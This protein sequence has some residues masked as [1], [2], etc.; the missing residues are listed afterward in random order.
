MNLMANKTFIP[1]FKAKV[2]DWNYYICHMKYAEVAKQVSFAYE[3]GGNTEL[4][5]MIQRGI[6]SR[7]EDITEYLLNSSHR[8][9]GAM[10]VAAWGGHPEYTA[11]QMEGPDDILEGL[12]RDFGL[13]TFDGSQLYY[14]LD[15]QH[16]LRAIKNALKKNPDL[17]TEDICVLMVAHFDTEDGRQKTRRL[18]TNINRNAKSTTGSENIVLDEDDGIAILTRRFLTEHEFLKK[19]KV[20]KVF[21]KQGS[22]GDIVLAGNNISKSDAHS[23]TT[24]SVLYN[25]LREIAFDLDDSMKDVTAR[26]SGEILDQS[27]T[28]LSHRIDD[29]LISAGKIRDLYEGVKSASELRAPKGSEPT[30]HAFMRPA[31]QRSVFRVVGQIRE[32]NRLD[33][34]SLMEKLKSL[35]WD[36]GSAPWIAVFN[37]DSNKM[38]GS[39]E[40]TNLLDALLMAHLA[41]S[42]KQSIRRARKEFKDLVKSQYPISEELLFANIISEDQLDETVD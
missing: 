36:I 42:S 14:A 23:F 27:Y 24:I 35:D 20:V 39:K 2:G 33:W 7:T 12:D 21:Q 3:L 40:F 4:E 34:D 30:G 31:I 32:Q 10:I 22:E 26:P 18:F 9:L 29:L 28:V 6:S 38:V 25:C 13:L 11:I 8:F 41:P 1:A 15:G 17:A 16:R 19:P 5:T 37:V